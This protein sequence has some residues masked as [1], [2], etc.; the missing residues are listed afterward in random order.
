MER[1]DKNH[2]SIAYSHSIRFLPKFTTLCEYALKIS[3]ATSASF[4]SDTVCMY[5]SQQGLRIDRKLIPVHFSR[6]MVN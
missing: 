5:F 6:N 1:W 2:H 3:C 4:F